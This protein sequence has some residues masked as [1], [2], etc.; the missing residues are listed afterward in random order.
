[1]DGSLSVIPCR[2]KVKLVGSGLIGTVLMIQISD[3]MHAI[4]QVS[5]FDGNDR[6]QAW[7]ESFEIEPVADSL[8]VKFGFTCQ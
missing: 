6:C 5:W 7:L 1:M 2:S 3:N 8:Q 4:Y